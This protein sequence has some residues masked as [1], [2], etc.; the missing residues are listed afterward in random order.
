MYVRKTQKM[1]NSGEHTTWN[2]VLDINVGIVEDRFV[3][4][5]TCISGSHKENRKY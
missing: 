3:L 2:F 5:L 4:L 1:G